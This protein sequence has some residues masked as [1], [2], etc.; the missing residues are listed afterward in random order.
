ML[1]R[2]RQK[3]QTLRDFL[4]LFN[5][6]LLSLFYRAWQ[7]NRFW[8]S[9][10][11][12]EIV[13][14]SYRDDP[15]RLRAFIDQKCD[16]GST[17]F[18]QS[19][20][21]LSGHGSADVA[22]PGVGPPV[23][24]A[25]DT[26][27]GYHVALLRR[28]TGTPTR[29]A[30]GLEGILQDYFAVPVQ[31]IQF[32]GQ[33]LLLD[34]DNQTQLVEGGNTNWGPPAIAGQRFWDRQ[35]RFR[36]RLGPLTGGSSRSSC[37]PA[38]AYQPLATWC[39]LRWTCL[40]HRYPAGAEGGGG[41]GVPTF[42]GRRAGPRLGWNTW[43]RGTAF[44]RDADDAILTLEGIV[45]NTD[46]N[47]SIRH[48]RSPCVLTSPPR[49]RGADRGRQSQIA[50]RQAERHVA[51][52]AGR[53][54]RAV[55]VPH[56]LQRRGRALAAEAA[57][58]RRHGHQPHAAALRD[59]RLA[60]GARSDAAVDA[61]KTGNSRPPRSSP[62]IVDLVREAWVL[63][64]IE[65]GEPAVALRASAAGAAGRRRIWRGWPA[66]VRPDL[67][68]IDAESLQKDFRDL[69]AG[70]SE[71]AP[72]ARRPERLRTRRAGVP[73]KT[74]ALD[75]FTI[76]LTRGPAQ[77]QIDPVL[78]RDAEIRQVIDILTRRRQNNPILTG[79]AGVGK[80]AVVEGFALRVAA[81]DVPAVAAQRVD[82]HARPGPAA[83]R[84]R[85][86]RRI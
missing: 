48:R 27:C 62:T 85:R 42:P 23:P 72:A 43:M 70:S 68:K 46:T 4:D 35:S 71:D 77:G 2:V 61:F 12:A 37:R 67:T 7:K 52:C 80:T 82:P 31:I 49:G 16:H 33:W 76:D 10:E 47:F 65:F 25:A 9:Y 26:R 45:L 54:R 55:S 84:G 32:V 22:V 79:E 51:A 50:D 69:V 63:A 59:R 28:T 73:R 81:G 34:E 30:M 58:G 17:L 6:R 15:A 74:V 41:A 78:G 36:I 29:S 64:S 13:G 8:I 56:E 38:A 75:Q 60:A 21:E 66:R 39:G 53:R 19:L 44:T 40:G 11:Q 14:R 5:H 20:L 1:E 24:A 83:G 3:D 18:S 86:E 57:G